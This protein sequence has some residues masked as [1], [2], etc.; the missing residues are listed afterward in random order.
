M[1]ILP[2]SVLVLF[3]IS[4][5]AGAA[6]AQTQPTATF[7]IKRAAGAIAIAGDLS[8][9]GSEDAVRAGPWS[10]T[11]A[12][13]MAAPKVT[14]VAWL[15]YDDHFFYSAFHFEDPNP[16]KIRAPLGD[17]DNVPSSTDYGGVILDTRNDGKTAI[18][19]LSNARGIQYDS[20][21]DDTSGNE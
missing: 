9:A 16:E 20:V 12:A 8:D 1:H 10:E 2:R 5:S 4:F 19:F 3:L 17:R 7:A 6:V 21:S 13:R 11:S 14:D 18:L 15:T